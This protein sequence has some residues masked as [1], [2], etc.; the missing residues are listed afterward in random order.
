MRKSEK[1]DA[2]EPVPLAPEELLDQIPAS[3][4]GIAFWDLHAATGMEDLALEQTLGVLEAAGRVSRVV[5][6]G[7]APVLCY[8][9]V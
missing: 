2:V 1:A 6:D 5:N 8:R 4:A 9:R 7:P 3:D